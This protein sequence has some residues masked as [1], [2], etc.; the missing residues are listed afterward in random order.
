MASERRIE[1]L[2]LE[3]SAEVGLEP[4]D[5]DQDR[6]RHP[7]VLLDL[8]QR[9]LVRAHACLAAADQERTDAAGVEL[10]ERQFEGALRP[11]EADHLGIVGEP[12][13]RLLDRRARDALARRRPLEVREPGVEAG[14]AVAA[15]G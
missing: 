2:P 5:G 4:P 9:R 12:G 7:E 14:A 8:R 6:S 1:Y 3:V 13:Q 15:F 10:L 11:V